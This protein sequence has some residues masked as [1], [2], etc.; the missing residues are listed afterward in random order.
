[1]EPAL[2][3]LVSQRAD[4]RCEYCGLP[5]GAAPFVPFHVEH[6]IAQQHGGGDE[7]DNLAWS[8]HR[9]NAYKGPNL[10][11]LDPQTGA[12]VRLFHPRRDRWL[13]HFRIEGTTIIGL[14][15]S[16]RATIRLLRFNDTHR[17][18]LRERLLREQ[19][20]D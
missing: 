15:P 20:P 3:N 19:R 12:L 10:A 6:I 16:G 8:C 7:L 9:C 11:S 2:R 18:E 1:M 5:Q 14:T 4:A 13:E 17:L